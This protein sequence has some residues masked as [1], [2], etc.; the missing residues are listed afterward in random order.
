MKPQPDFC[1][2]PVTLLAPSSP[3]AQLGGCTLQWTVAFSDVRA[4]AMT[5]YT[6][7]GLWHPS[8]LPH[9]ESNVRSH[10][11][12]QPQEPAGLVTAWFL[13]EKGH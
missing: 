13:A 10:D 6:E 1:L 9:T 7:M 5:V 11:L 3:G 8:E 2:E 4:V 12:T